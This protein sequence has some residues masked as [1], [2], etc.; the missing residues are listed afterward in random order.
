MIACMLYKYSQCTPLYTGTPC[1]LKCDCGTEN[2]T[3]AFVHPFLRRNGSDCFAGE[4]S[5]RYG[6][7]VSNQVQ[8]TSLAIELYY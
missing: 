8:H 2:T 1:I 6:K 4:Y 5:F 7:S 3:L